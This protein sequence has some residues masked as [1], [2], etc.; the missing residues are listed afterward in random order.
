AYI[1]AATHYVGFLTPIWVIFG[2]DKL[3]L[4]LVLSLVLGTTGW[5]TSSLFEVPMGA[6]ADKYG[7]KMSLISGLALCAIGDLSLIAFNN[8]AVLIAFQVVAGFGFALRSGSLE[9]L[10]HDSFEAVGESTEYSKLS[11]KMLFLVNASRVFT[12]PIGAWLYTLSID[13]SPSSYTYPYMAS[14][15]SFVI[16]VLCATFLV[17][18][19]TV[20]VLKE[21]IAN[22][23]LIKIIVR[24]WKQMSETFYEMMADRDVKRVIVLLGL[25]AFIGEGNW[26]LY[27]YYF[28]ERDI[29]LTESGWVYTVLVLLMAIGSLFVTKVYK[30]INVMWALNLI[31]ALVSFN[32]ILMHLPLGFAAIGFL[33]NAFVGPMALYLHDNAIQNRM[34][35]DKKTTALSIASMTYNIGAMLGVYGIGAVAQSI[36]VLNA[37]WYLVGYGAIVFVVMGAWCYKDGFAVRAEDAHA[38]GLDV[39]FDETSQLKP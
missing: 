11:S 6:V 18:M 24:I 25:Y 7:R 4:S 28:R 34:K 1:I 23:N 38:T 14:V 10:L 27:Q 16:A 15:A 20:E 19:H 2:T 9:G 26:A 21:K 36:G 35:G 29:G 30:K 5:V 13:S 17:E 8:F 33:V 37:Q 3:G 32:I 31:I 39:S 12:V 22:E